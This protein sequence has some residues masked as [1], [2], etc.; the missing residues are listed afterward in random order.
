MN[1][2]FNTRH[3]KKRKLILITLTKYELK[4]MHK[5]ANQDTMDSII[6]QVT[7]EKQIEKK[8]SEDEEHK[9]VKSPT[10]KFKIS[11]QASARSP[12]RYS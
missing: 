8:L 11:F 10:K 6:N 3:S 9:K 5:E 7:I 12:C 2:T 1:Q 4:E